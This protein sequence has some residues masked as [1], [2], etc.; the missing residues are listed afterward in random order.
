[1]FKECSFL[2][3]NGD[4]LVIVVPIHLPLA[5]TYTISVSRDHIRFKAGY[6]EIATLKY[7]GGDIFR[8][9][10]NFTE[11]GLVEYTPE[12]EKFPVN[13]THRA[14]VDIRRALIC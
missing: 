9:I 10:M 8:R 3:G 5:D 12:M 13:I 1:V 7:P 4:D 11:I 14:Y 6:N 2:M